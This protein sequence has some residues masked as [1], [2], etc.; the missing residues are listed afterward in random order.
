MA[1]DG[2]RGI[3][4][5]AVVLFHARA[6]ISPFYC[7]LSG[8]LAVDLF[9]VLSG[10]VIAHS[11]EKR[12]L[13]GLS[14][15]DF[16]VARMIRLQPL[17]VIGTVIGLAYPWLNHEI[18]TARD[19]LFLAMIL[20]I[21]CLLLPY[22]FDREMFPL[23]FA[24][25]SLFYELAINILFAIVGYR[26]RNSVLLIVAVLFLIGLCIAGTIEGDLN[27]G[28]WRKDLFAG[29]MRVGYSFIVGMLAYRTRLSWSAHIPRV[30]AWWVLGATA[31]ALVPN[32][33]GTP[34]LLYDLTFALV[35]S[36][37]IVVLG[38]QCTIRTRSV[39][40]FNLLGLLSFPLY[41]FHIPVKRL[42]QVADLPDV[43]TATLACLALGTTFVSALIAGLWVDP[44]IRRYLTERYRR[45]SKDGRRK[46][47]V[48]IQQ[49]S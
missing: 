44:I 36:P 22:I 2:I 39:G 19:L 25:W 12:L 24:A 37:L 5:I 21:N 41:A 10:F 15:K 1:L 33:V 40:I 46:N 8:Y 16:L 35:L 11:Y 48:A 13:G 31:L 34:R 26:M 14:T 23:N 29:S 9:F 18:S 47:L 20:V 30:S 45:F 3:A 32:F 27:Q 43:N 28:P 6:W 7:F 49:C 17:I 38:A 4:A 42:F